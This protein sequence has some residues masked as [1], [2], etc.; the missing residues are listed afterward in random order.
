MNALTP[1]E[2]RPAL[3]AGARLMAIVPTTMDEAYRLA[4]AICLAGMAPKGLDKPESC[5][6]AIMHGMEIGLTPLTALQRIAVVNGR[7]TIWGDG[8]M[9]L[10]RASGLCEYVRERIEGAGDNRAAVC[11]AQRRGEPEPIVRTFSVADA[12]R[13]GLWNKSGPWSQYPD[14]ML[15]MRARAF[16]LR[17]GFADVLG[18][19]YL[20]EE[21]DEEARGGRA[22]E[23]V[24]EP[25][26]GPPRSVPRLAAPDR[27]AEDVPA[28]PAPDYEALVAQFEDDA[29]AAQSLKDLEDCAGPLP[30][31]GELPMA[32]RTRFQNAW[33]TAEKR[34]AAAE[35]KAAEKPAEDAGD[36]PQIDKDSPDYKRGVSDYRAGVTKLL[37]VGIKGDPVR[38]AHWEAGQLDAMNAAAE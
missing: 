26:S 25:Q 19:L 37:N 35:A 1:V 32:L 14:R 9:S 27:T 34:I 24:V 30:N 15:Q 38:K 13:A 12:K 23:P 28:E 17:D 31:V 7:P 33:E 20:R 8:A 4:K 22:R 5:M 29:Q 6:V 3:V 11:E 21:M 10:V 36:G 16:A 2:P 18:G